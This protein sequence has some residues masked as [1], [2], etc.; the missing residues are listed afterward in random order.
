M[1]ECIFTDVGILASV[2]EEQF[3]NNA[4]IGIDGWFCAGKTV[5]GKNLAAALGAKFFDLDTAVAKHAGKFVDA[6]DLE[7]VRQNALDQDR[8]TFLSGA[9]ML[10]VMQ[11]T[12]IT[13]NALIY[14]KRVS[15]TGHWHDADELKG[16]PLNTLKGNS[17]QEGMLAEIRNYHE[18]WQPH[19]KA[20]FEFR[21]VD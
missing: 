20:D 9:F 10:E 14:V 17:H 16:G 1:A 3:Y 6:A 5:L 12:R 13:L 4:V 11:R 19:L 7:L 8:L 21:R 2:I 15:P 18:K